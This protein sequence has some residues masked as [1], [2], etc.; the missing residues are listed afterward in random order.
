MKYY[1][2]SDEHYGHTNIIKYC[3]RPFKTVEEMDG[4]II[5][6]HNSL[7]KFD[8]MVIHAG[9]FTLKNEKEAENYIRRLNG[10]HIFIQ[11]S[12]DKWNNNLPYV[13]E[14]TINKIH[15]VVCHYA[16]RVW[17]KSHYKNG[18]I[19][20]YGHSHGNLEPLKNQWDVG[21]DNNDFYPVSLDDLLKKI[22][23]QK[24]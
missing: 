7:V 17:P 8:D 24:I 4:E 14:K 10:K 23:T 1:F 9:D 13:W 11:G 15:I 19:M 18:S 5:K 22:N 3:N 6:R 21:V 12:H 20:F 2:T 16:M